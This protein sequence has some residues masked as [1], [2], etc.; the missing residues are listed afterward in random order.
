MIGPVGKGPL[1][2]FWLQISSVLGGLASSS[3]LTPLPKTARA[4]ASLGN[5]F[6]GAATGS[7]KKTPLE[8]VGEV[9]DMANLECVCILTF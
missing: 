1:Y 4:N 7:E 9:P 3:M 2:A 5:F 6:E 8:I